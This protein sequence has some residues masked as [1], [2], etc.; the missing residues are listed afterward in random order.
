MHCQERYHTKD[1]SKLRVS[2]SS[3]QTCYHSL[4]MTRF[5]SLICISSYH[6]LS[7]V[8]RSEPPPP[9][10]AVFPADP[11][12]VPPAVLPEPLPRRHRPAPRPLASLRVLRRLLFSSQPPSRRCNFLS[13]DDHIV[14][15]NYLHFKLTNSQLSL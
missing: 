9:A 10:G 11:A 1:Q 6:S 4:C 3:T 15:D 12:A 5:V 14:V 2:K 7:F 8:R 13:I